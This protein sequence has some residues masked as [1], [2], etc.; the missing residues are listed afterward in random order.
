MSNPKPDGPGQVVLTLFGG[1]QLQI[2]GREAALLPRKGQALLAYLALQDQQSVPRDALVDLLWTDRGAE[3]GRHSLRQMMFV[4]RRVVGNCVF[5]DDARTLS[6][7]PGMVTTDVGEFLVRAGSPAR[8]DLALAAKCYTGPL[9]G[10]FPAVLAEFD[11]WLDRARSD[12][13]NSAIDTLARLSEACF[14]DG[15]MA[16]GV[17]TAE[18]MLTLDP[19]REDCYRALMEA[20]RRV[21]RRADALRQFEVCKDTLRRELDVAPSPET[22]TLMAQIRSEGRA[23]EAPLTMVAGDQIATVVA[24]ASSGPPRLA[25]LPFRP[26]GHDTVPAYFA[27]GIVDDIITLLVN[28]REPV[29][30][31]GGSSGIYR[32]RP[33]DLRV[34]GQELGVRYVVSGSARYSRPLTRISVSLAEV[35]S[36]IVLW[37]HSYDARDLSLFDAQDNIA[38]RVVNTIIPHIHES[39][40]R[41]VRSKK[42]ESMTAYDLVLQA[43][44]L[45]LQLDRAAYQKAGALLHRAVT[46]DPNYATA[47]ALLADW[48]ALRVGQ[49]WSTDPVADSM[50]S[51][52]AA[53]DA[54]ARDSVNARALSLHANTRSFLYRDYEEAIQL[55]GKAIDIAPNDASS[56]MW[57]AGTYAYVDCGA[58]AVRRAEQAIRLSPRDR[59]AFRYYTALCLAHYTNES[60]EAAVHWGERA[61]RE[62]PR[63]TASLRFLIASLAASDQLPRARELGRQLLKA[64]PDFRVCSVRERHPYRDVARRNRIADQLVLAGLP[65]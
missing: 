32:D 60:Y 14:A 24:Q 23:E 34:V 11:Q 48:F 49:G 25:V 20:Y 19:L 36:G 9:L 43:R 5:T 7:M 6:F 54:I 50:A 1:F 62:A 63:Y 56:W 46:M 30:I 10:R 18:R 41:R 55:F 17:T 52:R 2:M 31:S 29:V 22:E 33:F 8:S 64:Q 42:P 3:Q 4:L 65:E 13:T 57:S 37:A 61:I 44:E 15:D 27:A 40:M 28:V 16:L 35:E 51:D 53:K 59:F 39:E 21:G 45:M 47:H 26:L 12:L 38:Q 58:E